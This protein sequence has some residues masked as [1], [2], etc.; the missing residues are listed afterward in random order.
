LKHFACVFW[1]RLRN[2][3]GA[4]SHSVTCVSVLN[5]EIRT[6]WRAKQDREHENIK[7]SKLG[8]WGGSFHCDGTFGTG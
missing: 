7:C 3:L 1:K 2:I 5:I 4:E 8:F 6:R